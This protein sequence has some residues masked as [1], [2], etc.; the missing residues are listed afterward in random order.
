VHSLLD[1]GLL[2]IQ[3][4]NL[5]GQPAPAARPETRSAPASQDDW[6]ETIFRHKTSSWAKRSISLWRYGS[7]IFHQHRLR[8]LNFFNRQGCTKKLYIALR[9]NG[10]LL[11][12]RRDNDRCSTIKTDRLGII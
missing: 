8:V 1:H 6:I 9:L 4:K 3:G 7:D 10:D 2:A 12:G 5:L 11:D